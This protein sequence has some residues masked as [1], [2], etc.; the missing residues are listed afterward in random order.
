MPSWALPLIIW[1]HLLATGMFQMSADRNGAGLFST[2]T[3]WSAAILV[4]HILFVVMLGVSAAQAWWVLP[5]LRPLDNWGRL[6]GGGYAPRPPRRPPKKIWAFLHRGAA[7]GRRLS[8]PVL[9]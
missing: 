9:G 7:P 1:L 4:E 2:A 3:P 6:G 5:N 8:T